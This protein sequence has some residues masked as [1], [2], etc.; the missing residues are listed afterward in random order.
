MKKIVFLS[1]L[2]LFSYSAI[3]SDYSLNNRIKD[4]IKTTK[5]LRPTVVKLAMEAFYNSRRLGININKPIV[6]VIDYSL[7]STDRRLWVIDLV[8]NKVLYNSMVAHG[9]NS[10]EK[11]TTNFSNRVGSLQ[12]SLGIFL[13]RGTYLGKDGY[14]LKMKG[15]EEGVNDKAEERY[16]VM[17]GAPYVSKEFVAASGMVGRSWGCPAVEKRLAKAIIDTVKEGSLVLAY[18]PDKLWLTNS[19]FV[20]R[21]A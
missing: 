21:R 19:K 15:L 20:N 4:I 18:Y 11:Y 8:R 9:V 14:S 13:T 6:T 7:P 16:I 10:G 17:H 2:S 3:A 5:N 12:T 1:I